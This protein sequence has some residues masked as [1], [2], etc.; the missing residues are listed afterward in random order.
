ML[1]HIGHCRRVH[2]VVAVP[3]M[4]V[5]SGVHLDGRLNLMRMLF[6]D[7]RQ[8]AIRGRCLDEERQGEQ[9]WNERSRSQNDQRQRRC[10]ASKTST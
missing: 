2:G 1:V 8:G 9:T 6:S 10:T 4:G 7:A 3:R 5:M